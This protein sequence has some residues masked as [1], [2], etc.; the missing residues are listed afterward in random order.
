MSK[1]RTATKQRCEPAE[2]T[3]IDA[4][5]EAEQRGVDAL[6]AAGYEIVERNYRCDV[7]ELDIIA[8]DGDD[9]VFVEVRSRSST[10]YGGASLAVGRGKQRKVT[11]VA[12]VY[13]RHKRP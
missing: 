6:V 13:L 3:T 11:K 2:P 10:D 12:E 4:G 8:R 1:T 7:G 9:L 5:A